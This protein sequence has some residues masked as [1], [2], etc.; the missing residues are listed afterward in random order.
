MA[1]AALEATGIPHVLFNVP[2]GSAIPQ[3]DDLLMHL[4]ADRLKYNVTMYCMS[5]FDMAT[6]YLARGPAFFAG[7]YRIGYRPGNSPLPSSM[8]RRLCP[9]RRNLGRQRIYRSL[10]SCAV[11]QAGTQASLPSRH[12][13]GRADASASSGAVSGARICLRL[14]I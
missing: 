8:E 2:A 10:A 14:S 3:Q 13:S 9:G 12:S 11:H 5:G 1:A 7:R 4:L 6:L